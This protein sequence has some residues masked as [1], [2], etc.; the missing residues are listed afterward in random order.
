MDMNPCTVIISADAALEKIIAAIEAICC[1]LDEKL[2]RLINFNHW[3]AVLYLLAP[4]CICFYSCK[5]ENK[6]AVT[7]SQNQRTYRMGFQDFPPIPDQNIALQAL[8]LWTLRADA[9]IISVQVPWDSLYTGK[10]PQ[11][12]IADNFMGLV[13][14]YRGKNLK[15]WVYIDPANGLDRTSDANDLKALGKSIAQPAVQQVYS[16][17]VFLMD[18]LLKP[19][20]LGLALETNLIRGSSPDSI[21]EGVKNA[22]NN[23]AAIVKNYDKNVKLSVSVQADYAWGLTTNTSYIGVDQDFS[24]FSFIQ[25]LGI[26]SYP[27]F[28]YNTPQD[29]PLNYYSRLIANHRVPVF[30]SEGGWSSVTAGTYTGTVQK[31]QDYITRQ[32]Q[33]LGNVKAIGYFQLLFSD[34]DFPAY[35][36]VPPTAD[37]FAYIGLTDSALTPKPALTTWD[38]LF[39]RPLAPGN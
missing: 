31:Q 27:Y 17:F 1:T 32:G 20:H 13:S 21:Y 8:N 16:R 35:P 6:T 33:L 12:Y 7:Q 23:T 3:K 30:V 4:V 11:E 10:T 19:D 9:A 22:A 28:V 5:H 15:L 34:I 2:N 14:Y 38:A 24:D 36:G 18:S 29:I 26:S 37:L 25:E 39:K